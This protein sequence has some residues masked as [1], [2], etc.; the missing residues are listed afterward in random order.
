M[1]I[2]EEGETMKGLEELEQIAKAGKRAE[3]DYGQS[4]IRRIADQTNFDNEFGPDVI[5]SLIRELKI[6]RLALKNAIADA[7][8]QIAGMD[9]MDSI[10]GYMKVA[11]RELYPETEQP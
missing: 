7:E 2:R 9:G 10:E 5:L 4:D 11:E 6:T 8:Q 3:T 1:D